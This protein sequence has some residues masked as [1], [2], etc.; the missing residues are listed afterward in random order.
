MAVKAT[1]DLPGLLQACVF[2]QG[3]AGSKLCQ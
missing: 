2:V 1:G 3:E